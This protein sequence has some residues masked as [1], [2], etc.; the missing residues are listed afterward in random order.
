MKTP[1]KV[2]V[3]DYIE[4]DL[5]W[6][7][8][9]ARNLG[10]AFEAHQLS[11]TT[12]AD[13]AK[14]TRDAHVVVVNMAPITAGL[15]SSWRNCELVIRH[16]V[17]YD[18]VDVAALTERGIRFCN[19]PDYCV[20]EVAEQ[21]I[22]LAFNLGRK[23]SWSRSVLESSSKLGSW[24]FAPIKPIHR[25]QGQTF[26][27]VGVGRIGSAVYQGLASFGFRCLVCDPYLPPE[28]LEN[29]GI[30]TIPMDEL[31]AEADFISLH[32][33]LNQETQHMI[34]RRSL[35]RMKPTAYLINTAR[36]G[37][38]DHSALYDALQAGRLAGAALDVFDR[39]PPEP[40]NSLFALENVILTPHLSWYSVEADQEIREKLFEQIRRYG[41]GM[42]PLN[43]LNEPALATR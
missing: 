16:G 31:L 17:G 37:L 7:A 15:I 18:N 23:I 24:D 27:I 35:A 14:V 6:E 12:E 32:V 1:I 5:D 3:T 25:M 21:A 4:P 9:E 20:Q 29:L 28:R 40:E 30:E 33:P 10:M 26:G 8:Q 2:V 34:N 39:E 11:L 13:L 41:K 36:A 22:A 43:W 38:I 42:E 19:I